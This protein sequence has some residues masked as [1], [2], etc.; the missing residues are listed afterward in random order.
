MPAWARTHERLGLRSSNRR[1]HLP[2]A[3]AADTDAKTERAIRDVLIAYLDAHPGA[4]SHARVRVARFSD[5]QKT[6]VHVV[7]VAALLGAGRRAIKARASRANG[8]LGGRP[9]MAAASRRAE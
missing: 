9:R 8:R 1:P 3:A 6:K 2:H 7:G 5:R 4:K